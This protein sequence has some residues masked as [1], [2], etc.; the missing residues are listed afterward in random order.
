M[1][2]Q[3]DKVGEAAGQLHAYYRIVLAL[4]GSA[5]A[6]YIALA[7]AMK[8]QASDFLACFPVLC[9]RAAR[10]DDFADELMPKNR[11]GDSTFVTFG[12]VEICTA[13]AAALYRDD[14]LVFTWGGIVY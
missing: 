6:A 10:G 2:V 7:T 8:G 14:H 9:Y 12:K 13:D 4:P 1:G 3:A 5:L 11:T